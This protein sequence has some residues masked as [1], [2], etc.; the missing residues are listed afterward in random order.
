MTLT[1]A[2]Y[3]W[4]PQQPDHRDFLFD[5]APHA[6]GPLPA[7]VDPITDGVPIYDQGQLG[8]CTGNGIARVL[9]YRQAQQFEGAVTPSRLF[10]YYEERVIEGTV[11]QDA[12]A[13]IRDGIKVVASKG[14]PPETDW[15]Y[16]ISQ[17]AVQPPAPAYAEALKHEAIRYEAIRNGPGAPFRT[18][19]AAGI[20]IVFGFSVPTSFED[21]SWNPATDILPLPGPN[22]GFVGG[23]C[24]VAS[25]YDFTG[26]E[27][28]WWCDNSWGPGWGASGRFRMHYRYFDQLATDHWVIQS[29]S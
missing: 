8:S 28:F 22:D 23:H 20:P 13:E 5:A 4:R 25:G 27:P 11:G 14:A 29:V 16:D 10:V 1:N 7:K 6:I 18:A 17:F 2:R 21:G 19:L 26:P 24:V 12:G 9:E 3:G 15:P